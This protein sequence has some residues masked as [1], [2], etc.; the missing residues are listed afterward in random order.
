MRR[1]LLSVTGWWVFRLFH[2]VCQKVL[3]WKSQNGAVPCSFVSWLADVSTSRR[4]CVICSSFSDCWCLCC[5]WNMVLD[6]NGY[7]YLLA[8]YTHSMSMDLSWLFC[9]ERGQKKALVRVPPPYPSSTVLGNKVNPDGRT[10]WTRGGSGGFFFIFQMGS[11]LRSDYVVDSGLL[12]YVDPHPYSLNSTVDIPVYSINILMCMYIGLTI[13][14][15]HPCPLFVFHRFQLERHWRILQPTSF[16]HLVIF[17]VSK[18]PTL[19][20]VNRRRLPPFKQLE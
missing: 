17:F 12:I 3:L 8:Q 15:V 4:L 5:Y 7:E 11:V 10:W 13:L 14:T 6:R 9:F 19:F 20:S 18:G 2:L 16:S 1:V